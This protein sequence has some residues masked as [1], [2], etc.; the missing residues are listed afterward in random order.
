MNG[1]LV[2]LFPLSDPSSL[3]PASSTNSTVPDKSSF[4]LDQQQPK[5]AQTLAR[6]NMSHA[7]TSTASTKA[8]HPNPHHH[9]QMSNANR[10]EATNTLAIL[11]PQ[12]KV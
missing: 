3:P 12:S 6:I 1:E 11:P 9:Q 4:L 8:P 5:P 10:A 2:E 7:S